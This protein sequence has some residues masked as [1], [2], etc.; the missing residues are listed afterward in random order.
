MKAQQSLLRWLRSLVTA[1]AVILAT[2]GASDRT[3]DAAEGTP[4]SKLRLLVELHGRMEELQ[5]AYEAIDYV[6]RSLQAL[7]RGE[8]LPPPPA[9]TDVLDNVLVNRVFHA[10][11]MIAKLD[12]LDTTIAAIDTS[13]D[14]LVGPS[15]SLAELTG[16]SQQR[17]VVLADMTNSVSQMSARADELIEAKTALEDLAQRLDG[18]RDACQVLAKALAEAASKPSWPE[19]QNFFEGAWFDVGV[20]LD[21]RIATAK[22][23][24]S[25]RQKAVTAASAT[26]H[27]RIENFASN[28]AILLDAE[29]AELLKEASELEKKTASL[30][31]EGTAVSEQGTALHKQQ[32]DLNTSVTSIQQRQN[33]LTQERT[34]L[35][36]QAATLNQEANALAALRN[37]I[38]HM[39]YNLCPNHEPF[40]SC[41]HNDLK[42][43]WVQQRNARVNEYNSRGAALQQRAADLGRRQQE[44]NRKVT[45]MNQDAAKLRIDLQDWSTRAEAWRVRRDTLAGSVQAHFP[46]VLRNKLMTEDNDHDRALVAGATKAP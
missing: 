24:A 28:V 30:E 20:I 32:E 29:R 40:A 3:A 10:D 36:N 18:A 6:D 45:A 1:F 37:D 34:G 31:A 5:N 17:R 42:A 11:G 14:V 25:D 22:A 46:E 19:L 27:T 7:G 26:L 13:T 2:V 12:R 9:Q 16:T 35:A 39:V 38:D 41:S 33:S 21:Q 15:P 8:P 44:F 23:A 43:R 4:I